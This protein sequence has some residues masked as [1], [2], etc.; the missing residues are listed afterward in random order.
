MDLI[1]PVILSGG[2]GTRLWPLSREAYPKQ[3]INLV[4]DNSL[5]GDTVERVEALDDVQH[6]IVV[7]NEAHRFMVAGC[8]QAHDHLNSSSIILEPVG[9]NTAP[10]IALAAYKAID[11]DSD[12]VLLIMPADH[13]IKDSPQFAEAVRKGKLA[14][15]EGKLAT[16]G[17]VPDCP[18]TG[19]GYIKSGREQGEW[20]V[21]EEF[22]EKPDEATAKGYIG[23]GEYYWNS[24]MF[25]F[26][27]D[28]YLQEL[29]KFQPDMVSICKEAFDKSSEDLDFIRVDAEIFATSPDDSIDYAVM[30][31]TDSAVVVPLDA[32]WSDVGSWSALWEIHAQDEHGN[33]CKGDVITE[34]VNNSYIHSESR[35]V[36]AI[37]VD[38]HV[39]VETDDV[40]LVADKSRVQDVKK[41]VAQVKQQDRHEHRFHKKVHRPWGTYEGIS[42]SQ[43]FQVKRIMVN[44]GAKLSLQK[45][46]HRA[47]HWVVVQ[48]T[49]LVTRGD[50][51]ILLSEDQSTYI[52]LGTV[53][54]LENPGVIPLEIIEVQTGSYLGEDDIVRLE[55][56]YGRS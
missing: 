16:F 34:D 39:I 48:G 44:P 6:L 31:K 38:D 41:L 2:S 51:Q 27:A 12:A 45:H 4:N 15:L 23:T 24:G 19:Y 42:S 55:D 21:V 14:A 10:A 5:L 9:R 52:P 25:M 22:V 35:L 8:L 17:I 18:H 30:E 32:G 49:A 11:V 13:V 1:I 50:E 29:E 46:H 47:E 26:R 40:I 36:A 43:R 33:V 20:A 54:R 37:G 3:F 56:T 53:H 28:R 7:S